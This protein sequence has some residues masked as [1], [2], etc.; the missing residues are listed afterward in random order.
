MFW[1]KTYVVSFASKKRTWCYT[2][3]WDRLLYSPVR[4][5]GL[6]SAS[7]IGLADSVWTPVRQKYE[8]LLLFCLPDHLSR[9]FLP[10]ARN[11]WLDYHH[12]FWHFVRY[13]DRPSLFSAFYVLRNVVE[14]HELLVCAFYR[15]LRL[16][17]CL[18]SLGNSLLHPI[19]KVC[20]LFL[21]LSN[22]AE[23]SIENRLLASQD[24]N[25]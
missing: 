17:F 11:L 7:K 24:C 19:L 16:K 6:Y 20:T 25:I 23:K 4:Q 18:V 1:D 14:H 12:K 5:Q 10:S 8:L 3:Y 2:Y 13:S 22:L 15:P 21:V 9:N